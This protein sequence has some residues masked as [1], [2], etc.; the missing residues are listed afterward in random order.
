MPRASNEFKN[1]GFEVIEATVGE[2]V[3]GST[4]LLSWLPSASSLELSHLI[5][6]ELLAKLIQKLKSH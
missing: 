2:P 3:N 5:L 6:R 4:N 1:V